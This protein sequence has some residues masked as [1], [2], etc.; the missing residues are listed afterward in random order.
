MVHK[1]LSQAI[2]LLLNINIL[3]VRS[4]IMAAR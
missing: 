1:K 4:Y 2:L 3:L